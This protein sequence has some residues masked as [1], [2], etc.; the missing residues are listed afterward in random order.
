MEKLNEKNKALGKGQQARIDSS[1]LSELGWG[2]HSLETG[3][4]HC[5]SLRH[6][7]AVSCSVSHLLVILVSDPEDLIS[8]M[9]RT[10]R[11][12]EKYI[13]PYANIIDIEVM[14]HSKSESFVFGVEW[15]EMRRQTIRL[16]LRSKNPEES[17]TITFFFYLFVDL[18][19]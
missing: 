14:K 4:I 8:Q 18:S 10:R 17:S 6:N 12:E 9:S 15:Q 11:K 13:I 16:L 2:R 3:V 7:C 1:W 19:A 5:G